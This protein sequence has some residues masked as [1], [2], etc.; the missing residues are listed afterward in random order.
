[1]SQEYKSDTGSD[2]VYKGEE[3]VYCR[4]TGD[5]YVNVGSGGIEKRVCSHCDYQTIN[6]Y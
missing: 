2:E 6:P 5:M 3:C 1:M 4:G